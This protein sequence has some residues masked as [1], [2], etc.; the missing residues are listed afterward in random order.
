MQLAQHQAGVR[1]Y[2]DAA[3][4]ETPR[5]CESVAEAVRLFQDDPLVFE[6]GS[7]TAYSSWGYVLLS[8]IVE[9]RADRPFAE[10][11]TQLVL[12]PAGMTGTAPAAGAGRPAA[13]AYRP[14]PAGGHDEVT[15]DPSCK[16]GAGGYYSTAADLVRFYGA[17][18]SG[19]LVSPP[20]QALILGRSPEGRLS[21][22]GASL[23]GESRI[24]G[25]VADG[26]FVAIVA[27]EWNPAAG[28]DA[29]AA[30]L[31]AAYE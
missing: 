22:G 5:R 15:I 25:R 27:N 31:L 17:L 24:T 11:L 1:H 4:A 9:L 18:T 30:A 7:R 21:F 8:R 16:W 12:E 3:E 19:K 29:V 10:A 2:R 20:M 6:P 26:V 14:S 28:L 23:G 13:A